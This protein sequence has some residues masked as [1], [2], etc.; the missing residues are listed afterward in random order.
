MN[1]EEWLEFLFKRGS[2]W[3][4]LVF[5]AV[6]ALYKRWK[7]AQEQ[8]PRAEVKPAP[9]AQKLPTPKP[10]SQQARVLANV[11]ADARAR[12]S[13]SL[14]AL[15]ARSLALADEVRREPLNRRFSEVLERYVPA[16]VAELRVQ[17]ASSVGPIPKPLLAASNVLAAVSDELSE[18]VRQRR[19]PVLGPLLADVDALADACYDP[20]ITHARAEGWPLRTAT[21]AAQLSMFELALWTG[22]APTS[23]APL[24]LPP[25]MPDRIVWWP[26]VGHEIGHDFLI[27][28]E[29]LEDALRR[30]LQLAPELQAARPARITPQGQLEL[31]PERTLAVWFEEVFADAFGVLMCGPAYVATMVHLFSHKEDPLEVKLVATLPQSGR[32]D[33]HPPPELRVEVAC[34]LLARLGFAQE[35]SGLR[36]RWRAQ[37]PEERAAGALLV[38]LHQRYLAVDAQPY[39]DAVWAATERLVVGPLPA[40]RGGGLQDISGL[41]FGPHEWA[42]AQRAKASFLSG[43]APRSA[44][45]RAVIAG[46]VLAW[47]E[48]PA[49][50]AQVL[51]LAR[52]AVVAKGS[53]EQL[54]EQD[55]AALQNG[56]V[57]PARLVVE[58]LV[59]R[60][61]LFERRP[62]R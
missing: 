7:Q 20:I 52:K 39:A 46:A 62:N 48:T 47:Q 54:P 40:L 33:T 49:K 2:V 38:P 37:N 60:E 11:G 29:G 9:V 50:E 13:A 17:L 43:Q 35:A 28:V 23:V 8:R 42:Q 19:D 26:A 32:L 4:F 56:A 36:E 6:S 24:F 61:L 34:R 57:E 31:A 5:W 41:D 22:F 16:Q 51:A 45:P 21:P 1:L 14:A 3:V 59:L 58:A 27:S 15:Q 12:L 10:A 55:G 30:D 53:F 18:L 25:E 44:D